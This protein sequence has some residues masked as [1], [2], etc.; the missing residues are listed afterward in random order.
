M[1]SWPSFAYLCYRYIELKNGLQ[2][3]LISDLSRAD[4]VSGDPAEETEEDDEG[5]DEDEEDES[6]GG[7]EEGVYSVD[8]YEEQR[9]ATGKKSSSSEKQVCSFP[10]CQVQNIEWCLSP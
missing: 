5:S 1:H 10:C 2:A 3:L 4:G 6:E 8:S 9:C 7:S